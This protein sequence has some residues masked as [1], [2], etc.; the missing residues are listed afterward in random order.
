MFTNSTIMK[1]ILF[2]TLICI[3]AVS[4]GKK[5]DITTIGYLQIAQDPS[6]DNAKESFFKALKDSGFINGTNI[7]ILDNNAQG[8]MSMIPT[9]LQSF[10]SQNVDIIVTN[11]TPCMIS[12]SQMVKEIPVVF[13]VSFS[14]KDM[15]IKTVPD[16]IY[17]VY[18][19]YNVS[20]F[21]D[22]ITSLIPNIKTV[23][24]PYNNSERNAEF[25]AKRI[26]SELTKR[27]IYVM[28]ASVNNTNDIINAG[29]Y[30][31][32]KRVEAIIIAADNVVNLGQGILGKICCENKIPFFVTEPMNSAEGAAIGYGIS[33]KHW[34]Y[35]SGLK[36]IDLI[37][38]RTIPEDEKIVPLKNMTLL[39]NNYT[40]KKQG[41]S[42]PDSLI[43]KADK[44]LH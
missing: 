23:G 28:T 39:I 8:D 27:N 14:P 33:Y 36:V 25:S 41:L 13:T 22:L 16:N 35:Q 26:I 31:K 6:L 3:L 21:A 17:G 1:R 43:K 15:G 44:I 12:A 5:S 11:G 37:K 29:N 38:G 7:K 40:A 42:I 18:D 19:S 30:L 2:I 34:G 10:I 4:C 32:D 24:L 9:I 20:K